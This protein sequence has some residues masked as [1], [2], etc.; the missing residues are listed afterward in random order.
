[1]PLNTLEKKFENKSQFL[2]VEDMN[3]K[4][5]ADMWGTVGKLSGSK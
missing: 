2:D 1:M 5:Y 3:I 4:L